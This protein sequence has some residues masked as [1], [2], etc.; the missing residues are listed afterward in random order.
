VYA[1]G[2]GMKRVYGI[3]MYKFFFGCPNLKVEDMIHSSDA[4]QQP[5]SAGKQC[6]TRMKIKVAYA[7][8]I[9]FG[10]GGCL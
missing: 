5:S 2:F 3:K 9:L 8:I 4:G 10:G 7:F 6:M 1:T